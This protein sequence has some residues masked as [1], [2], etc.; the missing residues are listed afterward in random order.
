MEP[1]HFFRVQNGIRFTSL[2]VSIFV[3]FYQ[4]LNG[5]ERGDGEAVD[6]SVSPLATTQVYMTNCDVTIS[7]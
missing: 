6:E 3:I 1:V 5:V 7:V 4:F 2:C